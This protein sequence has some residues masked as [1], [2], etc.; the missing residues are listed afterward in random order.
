MQD[1]TSA[2]ASQYSSK[3]NQ[4]VIKW[5]ANNPLVCVAI[6]GSMGAIGRYL[7]SRWATTWWGTGFP[8][9][10]LAVN[11]LG[12]FA[13]GFLAAL[14]TG[15]KGVPANVAAFLG[16]GF[17][18]AFTTFSTYSVDTIG[19]VQAGNVSHAMVNILLNNGLAILAAVLG[20]VAGRLF[21]R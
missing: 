20:I 1:H 4:N 15:H 18:G 11:V 7:V 19:H 10:I 21:I 14:S 13:L 2:T 8:L 6:G 12:S 5:I 16:I 17:C 3:E 9:G